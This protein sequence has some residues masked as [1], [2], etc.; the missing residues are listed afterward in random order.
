MLEEEDRQC[1]REE[2]RRCLEQKRRRL[3][4]EE[5]LKYSSARATS[6]LFPLNELLDLRLSCSLQTK[7][8]ISRRARNTPPGN[9]N[10]SLHPTTPR[11]QRP[12]SKAPSP[13]TACAER[14]AGQQCLQSIHILY[15]ILCAVRPRA[16]HASLV[17]G[18]VIS[19]PYIDGYVR[20]PAQAQH[21]K[22]RK[23]R[24]MSARNRRHHQ[25]EVTITNVGSAFLQCDARSTKEMFEPM[26]CEVVQTETETTVRGPPISRLKPLGFIDVEPMC[27]PGRE[28]I[29]TQGY[30]ASRINVIAD[31][32]V[33]ECSR[34]Q[35]M[36]D[37]ARFSTEA[38]EPDDGLQIYGTPTPK[39]KEGCSIRCYD[40]HRVAVVFS[41]LG[42]IIKEFIIEEKRCVE[43]IWLNWWDDLETKEGWPG[44]REAEAA[45]PSALLEKYPTT[46]V[47]SPGGG[48]IET[49]SAHDLLKAY[50]KRGSGVHIVRKIDEV[51]KQS[52]EETAPTAYGEPVVEVFKRREH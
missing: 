45:I 2:G 29:D 4:E 1:K 37:L 11:L 26:G 27:L 30:N 33:K 23:Q 42:S 44:F 34:V 51:I 46:H 35:A 48:I 18:R 17:G 13:P 8:N 31:Q 47:I 15:P 32:R 5:Y 12:L 19:W 40:D 50:V 36:I 39:F 38:K 41:V 3:E 6:A 52:G 14:P 16:G 24:D 21:R 9:R 7:M 49:P 10:R 43:K 25:Y 22:R 28:V 20:Q